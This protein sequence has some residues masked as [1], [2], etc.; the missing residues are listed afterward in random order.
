MAR[1]VRRKKYATTLAGYVSKRVIQDPHAYET[2][3]HRLRKVS[4]G[5]IEDIPYE[6]YVAKTLHRFHLDKTSLMWRF[7]MCWW[8]VPRGVRQDSL[9]RQ[10]RAHKEA[11]R[12]GLESGDFDIALV[13]RDYREL[14]EWWMY[15]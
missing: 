2:D 10:A 15:Y 1:T 5:K 14:I 4:T 8:T 3:E 12:K 13:R 9:K 7:E 6:T 11:I